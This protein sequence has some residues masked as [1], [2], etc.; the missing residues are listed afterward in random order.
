M[1]FA[2][3]VAGHPPGH[4]DRWLIPYCVILHVIKHEKAQLRLHGSKPSCGSSPGSISS[5]ATSKL[6]VSH[7]SFLRRCRF[8]HGS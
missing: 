6:I 5:A 3:R 7:P 2:V 4:P 1:C 8:R